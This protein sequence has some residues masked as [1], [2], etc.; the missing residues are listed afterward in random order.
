MVGAVLRQQSEN[1]PCNSLLNKDAKAWWYHKLLRKR[2]Q[3]DTARLAE[4]RNILESVRYL[5]QALSV[6]IPADR[7]TFVMSFGK[8]HTLSGYAPDDNSF[9]AAARLCG[10][11]FTE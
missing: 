10:I 4:R 11:P 9:I 1:I 6:T 5:R 3:A 8:F 2:D 7:K